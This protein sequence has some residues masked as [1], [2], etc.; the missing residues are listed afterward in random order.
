MISPVDTFP[1]STAAFTRTTQWYLAQTVNVELRHFGDALFPARSEGVWR[2]HLEPVQGATIVA[3]LNE[4]DATGAFLPQSQT[5]AA[6]L[7][8]EF[9]FPPGACQDTTTGKATGTG[10]V[11]VDRAVLVHN[12]RPDFSAWPTVSLFS[13]VPVALLREVDPATGEI[14]PVRDESALLPGLQ[15]SLQPGRARLLL[16][17]CP[18]SR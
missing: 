18:T 5:H 10:G 8:G 12:Q 13:S 4:T 14:G 15:V 7:L 17:L 3:A 6:Y 11:A 16:L 1:P 2:P 9:S